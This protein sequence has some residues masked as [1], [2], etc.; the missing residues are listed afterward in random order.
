M[1]VAGFGKDLTQNPVMSSGHR[2]PLQ[3]SKRTISRLS[4]EEL[5]TLVDELL[6]AS[7][8]RSGADATKVIV[9]TESKA[10][11]EGCDAWSPCPFEPDD[12]LGNE[13]TCWQLK[14][15]KAGEPSKLKGEVGKQIPMQTLKDG[16]RFVVVASGSTAGESGKRARLE[17]LVTEAQDL[18]IPSDKIHVFG[19]ENLTDWCNEFPAISARWSGHTA[20]FDTLERWRQSDI[21]QV[22]WQASSEITR[23]IHEAAQNLDLKTGQYRH[24]HIQGPAGVGK[25]RFAL[26]LCL[27][28]PWHKEVL[29]YRQAAA[30]GLFPFI[31][32]VS[33]DKNTKAVL[34]ID[35]VQEQQLLALRECIGR[36]EGRIRLLTIGH[37]LSPDPVKI[38][39]LKIQPLEAAEMKAL[40]SQWHPSMPS[41]HI[42]FIVKFADGYVRLA[43]LVSH[44][45]ARNHDMAAYELLNVEHIQ[46]ILRDLI[47]DTD[48]RVLHV[49]ALL[50]G[51]GW[52]DEA[53][54]E[55]EIIA[56]HL[57]LNWHDVRARVNAIHEELGVVPQGGRYRYISPNPL[58]VYLAV[59]AWKVYGNVLH[60]L[61]SKLPTE[62]ARDAF[63]QRLEQIASNPRVSN[64]T[65]E[66]LNFFLDLQAYSDPIMARR[67]AA[68]LPADPEAAASNLRR[69]LQ[70]A[71]PDERMQIAGH[72]RRAIV[73][74]LRRLAWSS[75]TF[76]DAVL[77]LAY[78][79]EAENESWANNAR[80][81]FLS[82]F[83]IVLGGTSL[84]YS[85][86]LDTLRTLLD[87]GRPLLSC[88]V[89]D[90]LSKAAEFQ[91]SRFGNLEG[92][93]RALETEWKPKTNKER[94]DNVRLGLQM[95]TDVLGSHP[96][97]ALENVKNAL[98][99]FSN[100]LTSNSIADD[101]FALFSETIASFPE[102]K[103]FAR[104]S[105]K[106]TLDREKRLQQASPKSIE[107]VKSF[108][109]K[110]KD[111][112]LAGRLR[113]AMSQDPVYQDTEPDFSSLAKE[114]LEKPNTLIEEWDWLTSG[115]AEYSTFIGRELGKLD[116]EKKLL[117]LMSSIHGLNRD[118][119]IVAGYI[120]ATKEREGQQ[121]YSEWFERIAKS[122]PT[123][124]LLLDV[125]W[126]CGLTDSIARQLSQILAKE[127]INPIVVRRLSWGRALDSI[128]IPVLKEFVSSLA[129]TH[130]STAIEI[131]DIRLKK[132]PEELH[133][134]RTLATRLVLSPE[135][136]RQ[137]DDV[138]GYYWKELS[139][140]LMPELIEPL[141]SAILREQTK[142][143]GQ[144][145]FIEYS[146]A[147]EVLDECAKT[148]PEVFWAKISPYLESSSDSDLLLAFG[149][150][151]G[152]LERVSVETLL[153]WVEDEPAHRAKVL[154]GI[155]EPNYG[156]DETLASLLLKRY[157]DMDEVSQ[158]F[159]SNLV[160]GFW[161]GPES[162]H[163]KNLAD[164]MNSLISSTDSPRLKRWARRA[165]KVLQNMVKCAERDEAEEEIGRGR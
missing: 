102:L 40:I 138:Q 112:S 130:I 25:T 17:I 7:C 45:I 128:S 156:N 13:E 34:V 114:L 37:S 83:Q 43:S 72:A 56:K 137:P 62:G 108:Y 39:C 69:L 129:E 61:T 101:V 41:E 11:D 12:W 134:W 71:S 16:G 87:V 14:A 50:V 24:I 23:Q 145:W 151:E 126:R 70:A 155:V 73:G 113:E 117:D 74:S 162:E 124:D 116:S 90:A 46:K 33:L 9:N 80:S 91:S 136:I 21:H 54:K 22:K 152:L 32:D 26:E 157:G 104:R 119:R 3:V 27:A 139:L 140:K 42:N 105:V 96:E 150:P 148:K 100:W 67:W 85:D 89:V 146:K 58:G 20:E 38:P 29:Y 123:W 93:G 95:L 5:D 55:G 110:L 81:E 4:D 97:V 127:S 98:L 106:N 15:G 19:S 111:S 86:R 52:T 76:H 99:K 57:N 107:K 48:R 82:A 120:N 149:L 59:D 165:H 47:R 143:E 92:F 132:Q 109:E 36:A 153:N 28:A 133:E 30:S 103:E 88:L 64:F 63:Y 94:V 53:A 10:K 158:K 121:W 159:I 77:S 79:A 160:T 147:K 6:R 84:P 31:N 135:A 18:G 8:Y 122:N 49:V 75:A 163:W 44:E 78:L 141:I 164:K 66:E 65:K 2:H 35:E 51:V 161:S 115:D 125:V 118:M 154:G 1:T 144:P 68:L 142:R 131:V 60:D